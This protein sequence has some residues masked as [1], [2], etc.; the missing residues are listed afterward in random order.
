MKFHAHSL[1]GVIA[2]S[3][4]TSS[5]SAE[6]VAHYTL[7]D[8]E[9]ATTVLDSSGLGNNGTNSG[10]TFGITGIDGTA[11][12]AGTGTAYNADQVTSDAFTADLGLSA[13]SAR[14]VSLWFNTDSVYGEMALFGMGAGSNRQQFIITVEDFGGAAGQS[15][16][17]RYGG[18]NVAYNNGGTA[19]SN[20]TWYHVAIVY[21][22][23]T[24]DFD[25]TDGTGVFAYI[26]GTIVS[27]VG[28]NQNLEGDVFNT[29]NTALQIGNSSTNNR[30]FNGKID[31]VQVYNS[32]LTASEIAAIY[33]SP[34]TVIPE[35]ST[36]ALLLALGALGLIARRRRRA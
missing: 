8:S 26:N 10:Q 24:I 5:A 3:V 25:P 4:F 21:D 19:L 31:D 9:P 6:L 11:I 22:G 1:I 12:Q 36:A 14:T 30:G 20:G 13:N 15:V 32:A 2:L 23:T 27:S 29:S 16:G 33:S 18:G 34:G 17:L 7:D 28:G 35:P